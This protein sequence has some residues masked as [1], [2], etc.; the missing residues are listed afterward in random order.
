MSYRD[1][2]GTTDGTM[3]GFEKEASQ[4]L[5]TLISP[6]TKVD[7]LY[8]TGQNVRLHGI[9]GVTITGFL[10]VGEM[11]G[12]DSFFDKVFKKINHA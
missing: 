9:L 11:L 6:K 10:T 1:Y 12:K 3:Y 7:N 2:I 4:P 5:K 8:L